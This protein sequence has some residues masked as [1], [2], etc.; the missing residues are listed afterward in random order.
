MSQLV[1]EGVNLVLAQQEYDRNKWERLFEAVGSCQSED[2]ES[3][4]SE[5]HDE[6]LAKTYARVEC[7]ST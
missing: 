6:F 1:R 5:R 4:V 7:S 3:H 2:R